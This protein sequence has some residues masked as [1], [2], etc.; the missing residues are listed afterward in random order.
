MIPPHRRK[1]CEKINR[2]KKPCKT[3]EPPDGIH[4]KTAP[5]PILGKQTGFLNIFT[6]VYSLANVTGNHCLGV[7]CVATC[8]LFRETRLSISWTI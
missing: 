7:V 4:S 2:F 6:A 3:R 1:A 5:T 8:V